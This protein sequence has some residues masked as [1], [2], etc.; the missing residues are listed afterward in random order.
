MSKFDPKE[1]QVLL[2]ETVER[3]YLSSWPQLATTHPKDIDLQIGLGVTGHPDFIYMLATDKQDAWTPV[4]RKIIR[5]VSLDWELYD[6][7]MRLWNQG[8]IYDP[9]DYEVFDATQNDHFQNIVG[10]R[11]SD[12]LFLSIKG[13]QFGPFGLKLVFPLDYILLTP[14]AD[15]STVE[16]ASF[17]RTENLNT[18]GHL[19]ILEYLS[20]GK[21]QQE[22]DGQSMPGYEMF[23]NQ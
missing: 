8:R 13:S 3:V 14:I 20:L 1:F 2:N 12:I 17:N 5:P 19:G 10:S 7:R 23:G 9:V 15:G 4:I 22:H 16:T 21:L 6:E 18:F 11:I